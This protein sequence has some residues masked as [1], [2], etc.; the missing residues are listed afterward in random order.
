M[1]AV[2]FAVKDLAVELRSRE[3]LDA[4]LLGG[5]ALVV[6]A[7]A[8][9]APVPEGPARSAAVLW[10]GVLVAA[11]VPLARSFTGEADRGTLDALLLLPVER[12]AI[13]LGK[14]LS[15]L[16]VTLLAGVVVLAA[17]AGLFGGPL[18]L[19]AGLGIVLLAGAAGLSIVGSTLAAI[20]AQARGREALLP[21]LLFPLALPVLLSA[22]PASVHAL[23]GDPLLAFGGELQLLVGYDLVFLAAGWL[24]FEHVVEG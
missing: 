12:S 8:A 22:V 17:Y 5:L 23:R 24:L 2:R 3:L 1:S 14:V 21:V 15:N 9:L 6:A 18:P 4:A 20:A 11:L 13:W 7:G 19:D 16:A 10:T